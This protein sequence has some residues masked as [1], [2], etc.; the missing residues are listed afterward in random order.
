A[1][2]RLIAGM[3]CIQKRGTD[4]YAIAT[5]RGKTD[6]NEFSGISHKEPEKTHGCIGHCLH[7][8]VS[9]VLHPFSGRG[10]LVANCE[11][12]NWI[13]LAA[14]HGLAPRN[15]AELVFQILEKTQPNSFETGLKSLNGDF[16]VA[17]WRENR[18]FL[19][20]DPV[21][22]KPIWYAHEN[23]R[24]AFASEAKALYAMGFAVVYEQNPREYLVYDLAKNELRRTHW[25]DFEAEKAAPTSDEKISSTID[26]LNALERILLAAVSKRI[27]DIPFGILFSGGLDSVLLAAACQKLGHSPLLF[28]ATIQDP[29]LPRPTDLAFAKTAAHAL[30]LELV[31]TSQTLAGTQEQIPRLVPLLE[32]SDVIKVGVALT[33]YNACATARARGIKVMLTGLGADELFGGYQRSQAMPDRLADE[34]RSYLLKAYEK[35]LYRDDIVS[36]QNS[37]ELRV[38]YYD[39]D[40]IAFALGL[41]DEHKIDG[42]IR[43]KILRELA[44]RWGLPDEIADRPKKASQY[45]S[46][47]DRAIE[48]LAKAGGYSSKSDFLATFWATPN[49]RLGALISGGKDSWLAATILAEKNYQISC[50]ITLE[51]KN[52]DSYMFHTPAISMV[53]LQAKAAG[54]PLVRQPTAGKEEAELVDLKT[55]LARAQTE[56][57]IQGVVNGALFSD[58][59]R[60]RIER[61]C[62]ELGLKIYSPLWHTPQDQE[63][64]ELLG[65]KFDVVFTSIACQGLDVHWLGKHLDAGTIA[66]LAALHKKYGI[67]VAGEGGEYESLVLDCPQFKQKIE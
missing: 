34:T 12:Y 48:K 54:I 55:A 8:V 1:Q 51:S 7:A 42:E 62:D 56:H 44:K 14:Q 63:L 32:T 18:V 26:P 5:E 20:R 2:K 35:D 38:P 61:V 28:H 60:K 31:V 9:N 22:I 49:Q 30:G 46:N 4:H 58:Y 27:P 16:A 37:V 53:G 65:R 43:K 52:P 24:F 66:E 17:Y 33:L 64:V 21:G 59:Q 39:R 29:T 19:F 15:D 25:F 40:V 47:A 41:A 57:G 36:M 3:A 67:N 23:G 50:L 13:E 10:Q 11:I 45:G 6:S